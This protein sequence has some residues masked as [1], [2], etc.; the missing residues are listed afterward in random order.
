MVRGN[1]ERYLDDLTNEP[2]M[3]LL[4]APLS[5]RIRVD[6]PPGKQPLAKFLLSNFMSTSSVPRYC[7]LAG[8]GFVGLG[9][10][11]FR[12]WEGRQ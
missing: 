1:W 9:L 5:N 2:Q 3:M 4:L 7:E 8:V 11:V 10:C 6:F 12:V